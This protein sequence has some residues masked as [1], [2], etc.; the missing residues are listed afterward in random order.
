ME[1]GYLLIRGIADE[2]NKAIFGKHKENLWVKIGNEEADKEFQ[3]LFVNKKLGALFYSQQ[4]PIQEYFGTQIGSNY[5]FGVKIK[6]IL[7]SEY[8]CL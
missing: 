5:N 8:F 2:N 4:D 6:N 1:T 7:P 3:N